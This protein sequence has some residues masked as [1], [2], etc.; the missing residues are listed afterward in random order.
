[1]KVVLEKTSFSEKARKKK[2]RRVFEVEL[3]LLQLLNP[4]LGRA[5]HFYVVCVESSRKKMRIENSEFFTHLF[6]FE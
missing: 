3:Y 2:A 6:Y 1:M 5:Q 4:M